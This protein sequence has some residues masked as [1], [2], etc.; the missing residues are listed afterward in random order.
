MTIEK[1]GGS[2]EFAPSTGGLTSG[3][4]SFHDKST[5]KWVGWPGPVQP[6][7][8]RSVARRLVN[9][10]GF[11]PVFLTPAMIRGYYTGF[12]NSTLWPLLH[13]FPTYARYSSAE[14]RAY[15]QV[16][17][18]FGEQI[19]RMIEPGDTVWIHDYHLMLLPA[20][21][22]ERVPGAKIGFF[23]HTPFPHYDTLRLIPWHRDIVS[24]LL[25][26]DLVG[27]HTYDY[28]QSFLGS[29][30]HILGLDN[31]IGQI[32]T[33]GRAVQVDVFPISVDFDQYSTSS[34]RQAVKN[35][36]ARLRRQTG[37]LKTIFSIS[38]LDYTKG[39]PHQLLSI[40]RLLETH[41]EMR[42]KFVY[43]SVVVPSRERVDLYRQ[44]KRDIDEIVGRINSRFGTMDWMPI[45]YMYRRL[46]D[47]EL[48]AQYASAHVALVMPLNDGMNLIAKEYI[49][50]RA[51]ETGV[52]V[53]S[54]MAGASKEL[55]EALIVNP[56]DVDEIAGS[57]HKA[58]T[59]PIVEQI[60]RN[61]IMR[62]RLQ[63]ADIHR[64]VARFLEKLEE[65]VKSS[66]NLMTMLM[67]DR[68][69]SE[70]RER[71]A[72]ARKRLFLLDYDGTL[73]HFAARPSSAAPSH[74]V[75]SVLGSLAT[76]GLNEVFLISGRKR[77]DLLAWFGDLPISL[78]AEHGVWLRSRSTGRWQ[79]L[80]KDK[81][82]WK[83]RIRPV[84]ELFVE[85]IP[86]SA[87]EEK[88]FSIAWHYRESDPELGPSASR[89]LIDALTHLTSNL[90][91]SVMIGN[92]VVEV[93]STHVNKGLFYVRHLSSKKWDFIFSAGDD[94]TDEYLFDRLPR[95]S[96]S[97]KVG[98]SASS[99]KYSMQ[100]P[101]DILDFLDSLSGL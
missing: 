29:I 75:L 42:R 11:F 27:F 10:F 9:D 6:K 57:L 59:M 71:Y 14:W 44:L 93:K 13:S 24:G 31:R 26:A 76:S 50:S 32:V 60:R 91:I 40:E 53:L 74:R 41:P 64:W 87:I 99:A 80:V 47:D 51:D 18:L 20:Y 4:K 36:I 84:L 97:V 54:E 1:H 48:S 86:G 49:A 3:L 12:S 68:T 69:K 15:K 94:E 98:I 65:A 5:M 33:R 89:E 63:K 83:N 23:L 62:A 2:V 43:L 8:Q 73:V 96:V 101:E 82:V 19:M 37:D 22:R 38:R 46:D 92:K 58:L 17:T 30:R 34:E 55:L 25:G 39:I 21:I 35:R 67:T 95:D 88:D 100:N 90:D 52:L 16:N 66:D 70:I 72:S 85:R 79:S 7:D 28:S 81:P 56:N 77:E 61:R 45:R 78:V